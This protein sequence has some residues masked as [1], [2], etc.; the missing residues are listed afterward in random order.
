MI[1]Q[2]VKIVSWPYEGHEWILQGNIVGEWYSIKE[3]LMQL[4]VKES[5][6]VIVQ[7]WN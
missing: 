2:K 1:M 7:E 5:D 4:Q 6:F 3:W